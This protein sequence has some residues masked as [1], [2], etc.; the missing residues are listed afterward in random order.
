MSKRKIKRG[1]ILK[2]IKIEKIWW[3]G[4]GVSTFLDWKKIIIS[5]GV[6]PNSVVNCRVIK[7]K[8][9]YI[10]CQLLDYVELP[11]N[12]NLKDLCKHNMIFK[13][14]GKLWCDVWCGWCKWQVLPYDEQLKLKQQ[15]FEDSFRFIYDKVSDKIN[16]ILKSPVIFWYRNKV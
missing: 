14:F 2:N 1:T 13:Y 10:Q 4:V 8:K 16:Y 11:E 6:L 5:W 3:G 12:L 15:L 9:D 7:N